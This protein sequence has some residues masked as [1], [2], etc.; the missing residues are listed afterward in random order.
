MLAKDVPNGTNV[1]SIPQLSVCRCVWLIGEVK[2]V[3]EALQTG[4]LPR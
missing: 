2:P 1:D 4:S 3:W